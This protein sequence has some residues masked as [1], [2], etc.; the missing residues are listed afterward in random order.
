MY[1]RIRLGKMLNLR[2]L[3]GYPASGGKT[4]RWGR[5]L[6]GDNPA[7]LSQAD[8]DWLLERGITTV[9][10]LRSPAEMEKLPD[11]L[12]GQPGFAYRH[13]PLSGGVKL[14]HEEEL[15]GWG[16]FQMLERKE[17]V[18]AVLAAVLLAA[19]LLTLTACSGGASSAGTADA[20]S[21][22]AQ[23]SASAEDAAEA[24]DLLAR[25]QARGELII[26]TEGTWAP[27]TYHDENDEL[28]GYDVE[29]ARLVAEKLGVTATFV[30]GEFDGLLA[31]VEGGRYDMVAN[32]VNVTPERA[33]AYSFSD[34]YLYD[35]TVV[36]V[37]DD[38]D[39]IRS[40]EDLAGKTTGNTITSTYA[41]LAESYG[42]TTQGVDDFAQTI[43]LLEAGRIDAT[44]NS[45]VTY[46]YFMS[47]Q[48][49]AAIKVACSD[50]PQQLALAM[51]KNDDAATLVEAV[52]QALAE[53]RDSGELAALSE[54]YFGTDLTSAG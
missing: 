28:V 47:Q 24:G 6:R 26:A 45:S 44:L 46:S 8:R 11:E 37:R 9:I 12:A 42:A 34:P 36:I 1:R 32:G 21:S 27:F 50:D 39:E 16:Y 2:D 38:Y 14:P 10:D 18:A 43:E 17:E 41:I 51:P 7:G 35:S 30:E 33:E 20:S 23:G 25:I 19:G 22:A 3:G 54:Q 15:V 52:N 48:P 29:V 49:D 13:L 4:T 5:L 53:L 40:M 31:G